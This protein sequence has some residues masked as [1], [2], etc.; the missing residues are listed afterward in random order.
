PRRGR[1]TRFRTP[2]ACPRGR[3]YPR[4]AMATRTRKFGD[5]PCPVCA[6]KIK[7]VQQGKTEIEVGD[8]HGVWL[9]KGELEAI[10]A[11][12]GFEQMRSRAA[13]RRAT[14]Q[15][16]ED[17]KVKGWLLGPLAFLFDR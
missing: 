1:D 16:L 15:A 5:R 10:R 12:A 7:L 9:D 6:T 3:R 4:C 13:V 14:T 2:P 8:E 11:V 17:D